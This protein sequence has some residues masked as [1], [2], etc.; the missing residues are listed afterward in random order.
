MARRRNELDTLMDAWAVWL[1]SG[2]DF[3]NGGKSMLAKMIDNHGHLTFGSGTSG[4][5][6]SV[7]SCIE[8]SVSALASKNVLAADIIRLEYDAGYLWV[9][10]RRGLRRYDPRY[11]TQADK[12]RLLKISHRTYL[13]HLK[14]ARQQVFDDL[15]LKRQRYV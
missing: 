7:E 6:D 11:T 8:S 12:A 9:L 5:V 10:K 14:T 1:S 2:G 4:P 13:R 15:Q 3:L